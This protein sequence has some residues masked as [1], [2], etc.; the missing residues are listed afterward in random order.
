MMG[1]KLHLL[2]HEGEDDIVNRTGGLARIFLHQQI[3]KTLS[4]FTVGVGIWIRPEE[5]DPL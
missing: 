2:T 4:G 1:R 3:A 5:E